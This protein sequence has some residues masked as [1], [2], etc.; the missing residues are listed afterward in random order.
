[1]FRRLNNCLQCAL[2]LCLE[3]V[4]MCSPFTHEICNCLTNQKLVKLRHRTRQTE[5][6]NDLIIE[7]NIVL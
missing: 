4:R 1:M 5:V 7:A 6:M 2:K 3:T